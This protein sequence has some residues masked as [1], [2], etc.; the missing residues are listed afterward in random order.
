M[1]INKF[2][3]LLA[4]ILL[5]SPSFAKDNIK[6]WVGGQVAELDDTWNSVIEK[7]EN[8]TGK[9][10]DVQ[11]FGFDVYY[12][13][14]Q[15]AL[16]GGKGPDLA[17]ADLGGWVQ[18]FADKDWLEP[19]DERLEHWDG[20]EQIWPNL[21]PTVTW[22]NVHYG[23]PWYTDARI[24]L[25][26]DKMFKDAGLD[27]LS[28]PKTWDELLAA[29]DKI[30]DPK[31]KI[32][33]YGQSGTR[34]EH[35]TLGFI[36]FLYGN[37]GKLLSDDLTKA[38][39][40]TKE[41][42]EALKFYTDLASMEGISPKA[43]S[44]N[45]DDYRNMMAQNRI[46][47]AVGGPWS[48]PLIETAN[49]EI[50]GNYSAAVHPYGKNPASVLGGWALV[51]PKYSE[52]KDDAWQLAQYLTSKETWMFWIDQKGGPMPTRMD[53]GKESPVFKN[54]PKWQV[55][56]DVF[57]NAIPRPGIP[58]YPQVSLEIQDMIQNVM[59]GKKTPEQAIKEAEEAVNTILADRK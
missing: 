52:N 10:V 5:A 31:K 42:L 14:L 28:P 26:N 50:K 27:P 54:D 37:G 32:F 34:T 46:A 38:A 6:I 11:L 35:T 8:Q 7:F 3:L 24:L 59:L 39:F 18:T 33:A 40:N 49:P 21:W 9:N 36:I 2:S 57:P 55:I 1:K 20:T 53:V 15:T 22:K 30:K 23:L 51:I 56:L 25:I 58:E 44:Y 41:G 13:K 19:L 48:F 45:E 47:M 16:M 4:A 12:D 29:S 17:F 43:V